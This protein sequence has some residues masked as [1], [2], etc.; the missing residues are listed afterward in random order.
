MFVMDS[1]RYLHSPQFLAI[2]PEIRAAL[3]RVQP[4]YE[5]YLAM[6]LLTF[7]NIGQWSCHVIV[8]ALRS[9]SINN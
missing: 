8:F 9:K 6:F 1:P 5:E 3:T 4:S 7:W 2:M